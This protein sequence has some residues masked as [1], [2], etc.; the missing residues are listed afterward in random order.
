S[1]KKAGPR[2]RG[3]RVSLLLVRCLPNNRSDTAASLADRHRPRHDGRDDG[4]APRQHDLDKYRPSPSRPARSGPGVL[5][6]QAEGDEGR[7]FDAAR[8]R[9]V[10]ANDLLG[11][12]GIARLV[13]LPE[14]DLRCAFVPE[15]G[16]LEEALA[17]FEV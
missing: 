12:E 6:E 15:D 1:K 5:G 16:P 3:R 11:Y 2:C 13:E 8:V 9:V 7:R 4:G 14:E 10:V 17:R